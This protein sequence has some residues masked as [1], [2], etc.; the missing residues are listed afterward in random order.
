MYTKVKEAD[1]RWK[2]ELRKG[3]KATAAATSVLQ[4]KK[5]YLYARL[6]L[7]FTQG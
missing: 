2:Q 7:Q 6:A 5:A 3:G 4:Y 1:K